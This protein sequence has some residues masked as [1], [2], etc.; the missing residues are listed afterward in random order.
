[1][2]LLFVDRA[3][4]MT[5]ESRVMVERRFGTIEGELVRQRI[6]ELLAVDNLATVFTVP[7]LDLRG[8]GDGA[9]AYSLQLTPRYRLHFEAAVEPLPGTRG[10]RHVDPSQVDVIRVIGLEEMK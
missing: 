5:L 8:N 7:T 10:N 4:Q 6:C 9:P 3:L 1:M 2:E